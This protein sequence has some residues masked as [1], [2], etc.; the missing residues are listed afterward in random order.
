[1]KQSTS[2]KQSEP[3]FKCIE[4][5]KKWDMFHIRLIKDRFTK[6]EALAI[7][8]DIM[9]YN[10]SYLINHYVYCLVPKPSRSICNILYRNKW[11]IIGDTF[12]NKKHYYVCVK[13]PHNSV[14]RDGKYNKMKDPYKI[15]YVG[16]ELN[17][18]LNY[19]LHLFLSNMLVNRCESPQ[20]ENTFHPMGTSR[21][22]CEQCRP[23]KI[24]N[25]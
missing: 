20:C 4:V 6:R 17:I 9:E 10:R 23:S 7:K 18:Y 15:K 8:N 24:K 12:I 3:N 14:Y 25:D 21:K 11:I 22:Y 2:S 19:S 1:M 13:P 5:Y 16:D